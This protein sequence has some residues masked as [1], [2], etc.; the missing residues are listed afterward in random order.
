MLKI[1]G[2]RYLWKSFNMKFKFDEM[3]EYHLGDG[4]G[5]E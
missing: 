1:F 2:K 3:R 5:R 4:R